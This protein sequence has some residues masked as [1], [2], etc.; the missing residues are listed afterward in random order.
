MAAIPTTAA[1]SPHSLS[2]NP[3]PTPTPSLPI[4]SIQFQATPTTK[5]QHSINPHNNHLHD[6]PVSPSSSSDDELKE[7]ILC[8]ELL[9]VDSTKAL[10]LN[11]SLRTATLHSINRITSFLLHSKR[12]HLD[13]LPRIFGMC[14]SLL[15]ASIPRDLVP[16]FDFLSHD[17]HVPDHKLRKVINKCPRLLVSSVRDQLKPALMYLHR[18]G[19][20]DL[21]ALACRDAVLLVSSVERTLMPKLEWLV[22]AGFTREEAVGMVRRCPGLF[23]FSIERNL[24]PKLEYLVEV[25]GGRLEEVR[26]FPQYFGFSLEKRIKA[27]HEVVVERGIGRVTIPLDVMLKTTDDHFSR[28]LKSHCVRFT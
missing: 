23:T 28:L 2:F 6:L 5:L 24:K 19:I 8:L 13:D 18:L 17:L 20:R 3:T 7:K 15:T 26:E 4:Q 1:L 21:E 9:G 16:V 14:P 25:M 10:S 27:R 11:P 22:E 12:L